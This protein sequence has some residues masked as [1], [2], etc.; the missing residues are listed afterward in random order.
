MEQN[1]AKR[2]LTKDGKFRISIIQEDCAENPRNTTDEPFHCEDF[3]RGYTIMNNKERA[4]CN[5]S[6]SSRSLLS[7]MVRE[8]GDEK[9]V[10]DVL[11]YNGKHMN[12]GENKSNDAIVYDNSEKCWSLMTYGLRYNYETYENEFNWYVYDS[13]YCRKDE[14]DYYEV[15][16]SLSE[17]SVDYMI[18]NCMTDKVKMAGYNFGYNGEVTFCDEVTSDCDG[19]CWLEKD[20]FLKYSGN[21]EEYWK[22]KS[23]TEIEFLCEELKAWS[24]NEVYGFKVEKKH[25][26]KLHKEYIDE[27]KE[28]EDTEDEEWE[29]TDS[30]WGFYGELDK[31]LEWILESAGYKIEE[32]EEVA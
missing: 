11:F 9:K 3:N 8:Y 17:E 27:D 5:R 6:S 32:L 18:E 10:L 23:L 13:Y 21:S 15:V 20:E 22:S 2:F 25:R 30:C 29:E 7:Y 24:E 14:I 4:N 12:D 31:S 28:D 1:Y 19:I 26:F 16:D